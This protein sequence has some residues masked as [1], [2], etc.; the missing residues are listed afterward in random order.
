MRKVLNLRASERVTTFKLRSD[1]NRLCRFLAARCPTLSWA[2]EKT[3]TVSAEAKQRKRR[4]LSFLSHHAWCRASG[5]CYPLTNSAIHLPNNLR[6]AQN[7]DVQEGQG[8]PMASPE[9]ESNGT[10]RGAIFS[11]VVRK[12][13]TTNQRSGFTYS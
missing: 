11:Y 7:F 10:P 1:E 12:C 4:S 13:G 2:A 8:E 5:G 6:I 3:E 9:I